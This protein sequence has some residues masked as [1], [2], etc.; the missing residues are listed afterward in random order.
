MKLLNTSLFILLVV[1]LSAQQALPLDKEGYIVNPKALHFDLR[2]KGWKPPIRN[3]GS[4]GSCW[5]FAAAAAFEANFFIKTG[6]TIDVSEQVIL[7]CFAENGCRGGYSAN[8]FRQMVFGGKRILSE[9]NVPYLMQNDTCGKSATKVGYMATKFG[10]LDTKYATQKLELT[11]QGIM[12]VRKLI[13]RYGGVA[14]NLRMSYPF[15]GFNGVGVLRDTAYQPGSS[16]SNHAIL[17]LGWDDLKKAWLIRNSWGEAWGDKGYAWMGYNQLNVGTD[18]HWIEAAPH[19]NV[20]ENIKP[21]Q[22]LQNKT[23]NL[24]IDTKAQWL[25]GDVTI[26]INNEAFDLKVEKGKIITPENII[27][28]KGKNTYEISGTSIDANGISHQINGTGVLQVKNTSQKISIETKDF[29]IDQE[30]TITKIMLNIN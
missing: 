13:A 8:V 5:A 19:D 15:L 25:S 1:K 23:V 22:Y 6:K 9:K 10:N 20:L 21:A 3:Q 2:D 29:K 12:E 4:C 14:S 17:I 24:Q 26:K 11:P 7:D 30:K 16:L 27:L 18:T 28:L